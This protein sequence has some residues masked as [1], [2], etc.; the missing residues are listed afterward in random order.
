MKI[1]GAISRSLETKTLELCLAE[2]HE[3]IPRSSPLQAARSF[4]MSPTLVKKQGKGPCSEPDVAPS[5]HR[6]APGRIR[7]H[8]EPS[9]EQAAKQLGGS[10]KQTHM[11]H[12]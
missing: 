2:L 5:R 6:P 9:N 3:F 12:L 10:H 11:G 1:S 8:N 4:Q 7:D